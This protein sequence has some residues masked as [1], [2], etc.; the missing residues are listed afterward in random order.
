V[1]NND[2]EWIELQCH[3]NTHFYARLE[4]KDSDIFK[5]IDYCPCR[6]EKQEV[7]YWTL[8]Y[9]NMLLQNF[10]KSIVSAKA[11]GLNGYDKQAVKD[12]HSINAIICP[13]YIYTKFPLQILRHDWEPLS[14]ISIDQSMIEEQYCCSRFIEGFNHG[15]HGYEPPDQ[16]WPSYSVPRFEKFIQ[17][18]PHQ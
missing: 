10:R 12:Q 17:M 13:K 8:F 9:R 6:E 18:Y 3:C 15:F 2:P 11:K 4:C 16:E 14:R 5:R 7:G 1:H